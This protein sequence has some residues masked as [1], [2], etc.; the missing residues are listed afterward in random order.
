MQH[1]TSSCITYSNNNVLKLILSLF[2]CISIIISTQYVPVEA[3]E[4]VVSVPT[5]AP[6]VFVVPSGVDGAHRL[7]KEE[8][9]SLT[10]C[11]NSSVSVDV[12]A[13]KPTEN[14]LNKGEINQTYLEQ[15]LRRA[16]I[17]RQLAAVPTVKLD[18][19][20]NKKAQ[21][22]AM[23]TALNSNIDEKINNYALI[24]VGSDLCDMPVISM[25]GSTSNIDISELISESLSS[26]V[27]NRKVQL[28]PNIT[29]IGLGTV[30][31]IHPLNID[32][33]NEKYIDG[34]YHNVQW[35]DLANTRTDIGKQAPY[36]YIAWPASGDFP[37]NTPIFTADSLWTVT[38]N[39][40][41][42]KT[43]KLS[44]IKVTVTSKT[45]NETY[46]IVSDDYS[47]NAIEGNII[48]NLVIDTSADKTGAE[49]STLVF[50]VPAPNTKDA[51]FAGKYDIMIEGLRDATNTPTNIVYSVNFFDT[52]KYNSEA[53]TDS[54]N[55][56]N[57]S[58]PS[59]PSN[60][61][62]SNNSEHL[63]PSNNSV[64]PLLPYDPSTKFVDIPSNFWAIDY[65]RQAVDDGIMKGTGYG[66]F[67]PNAPITPVQFAAILLRAFYSDVWYNEQVE[68]PSFI[69]YTSNIAAQCGLFDG[70]VKNEC[71]S[72]VVN[73]ATMNIVTAPMNRY[74]VAM[75]I[76]NTESR[77]NLRS[78]TTEEPSVLMNIKN[79]FIDWS[80]MP[81]EYKQAVSTCFA[82]GII[83]GTE[84]S[85]FDGEAIVTRAQAAAIYCRMLKAMGI[86]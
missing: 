67:N 47:G 83:T 46:I 65:I 13:I 70:L 80:D 5:S 21:E 81:E 3:S 9:V 38:L 1:V 12:Y 32:T 26:L 36:T 41:R 63:D 40:T 60:S 28:D 64:D 53:N 79:V 86:E 39:P 18:A 54:N 57:S 69:D 58:N 72:S 73:Q 17:I 35:H 68:I 51:M 76:S 15:T 31:D 74:S 77:T 56:N 23:Q 75:M 19:E 16:N 6:A 61:S 20:M 8:I 34:I 14:P 10:Q 29:D 48:S 62:N 50:K 82:H 45:F 43:P 4:S 22:L 55:F 37:S 30:S 7:S 44:E 24:S 59:N 2:I 85:K 42:F 66:K 33:Q 49:S 11:L 52:A 84:S 25:K 71:N 78:L 27:F